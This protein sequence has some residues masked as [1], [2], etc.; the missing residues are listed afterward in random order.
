MWLNHLTALVSYFED[1]EIMIK[2]LTFSSRPS[3]PDK[4]YVEN[5]VSMQLTLC[6]TSE[7]STDTRK[8]EENAWIT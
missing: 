4:K 7:S 5:K 8:K 3:K 2:H 1:Q 6:I